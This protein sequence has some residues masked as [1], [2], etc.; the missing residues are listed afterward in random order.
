MLSEKTARR[1]SWTTM[2]SAVSFASSVCP[3][4]SLTVR[5]LVTNRRSAATASADATWSPTPNRV[6]MLGED[7]GAESG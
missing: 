1:P 6:P 7:A 4:S 2:A 3:G 5:K